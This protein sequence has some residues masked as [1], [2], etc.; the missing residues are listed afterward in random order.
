MTAVPSVGMQAVPGPQFGM[1]FAPTA[2]PTTTVVPALNPQQAAQQAA[3]LAAQQM[4]TQMPLKLTEGIPTAEQVA[5]QKGMYASA[6]DKQL[7][8]A[9]ATVTQEISIS[10]QMATFATQKDIAMYEMQ[11]EERLTE[12]LAQVDEQATLQTLELKKAFVERQLQ[13]NTQAN[14]I[15]MEYNVNQVH[16]EIAAKQQALAKQFQTAEFQLASQGVQAMKTAMT[17]TTYQ[18]LAA[19]VPSAQ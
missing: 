4:P 7:Q 1:S 11:V 17:P 12:A 16:A 9:Q 18:V 15:V 5:T 19:A 6:L 3:M 13:L 2:M 14:G 10:K 8:Q